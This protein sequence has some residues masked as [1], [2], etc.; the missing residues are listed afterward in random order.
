MPT[1]LL[2][3]AARA[4]QVWIS[5]LDIHGHGAATASA[6]R[7]I[8]NLARFREAGGR[9]LYGTD[10]GNGVLPLGVNAREVTALMRAGLDAPA[11]LAAL[12]D[13]W[14]CREASAWGMSGL[15][16]YVPGP[17]PAR[18]DD[19]GTW[20]AEARVLPAEDLEELDR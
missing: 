7:A 14:P 12:T 15:T 10:L 1:A 16:T 9:V 5:T 20:L 2:A 3:R 8:A 19:L 4:G 11:V 6:A 13:P 18:P 17:P